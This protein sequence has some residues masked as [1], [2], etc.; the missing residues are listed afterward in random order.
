MPNFKFLQ[1]R[2]RWY[3]LAV[4][5]VLPL[6]TSEKF[7]LLQVPVSVKKLCVFPAVYILMPEICREK[8]GVAAPNFNSNITRY[9]YNDFQ[10]TVDGVKIVAFV[11]SVVLGNSSLLSNT[12]LIFSFNI[13]TSYS[14]RKF[15]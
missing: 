9:L 11:L 13:L 4:P 10:C 6:A 14:V 7:Q 12:I 1:R 8:S 3:E 5:C 15:R 2:F